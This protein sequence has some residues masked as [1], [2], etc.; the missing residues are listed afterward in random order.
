MKQKEDNDCCFNA[1]LGYLTLN[2][3]GAA[4]DI[5]V[6]CLKCNKVWGAKDIEN[7][8]KTK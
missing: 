1:K 8:K 5:G 3:L 6:A 7:G 4:K 2:R